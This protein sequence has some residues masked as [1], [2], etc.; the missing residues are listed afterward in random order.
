M[1]DPYSGK[2]LGS[3]A[4]KNAV[5]E[6]M[7]MLFSLHRWLLLDRIEEPIFRRITKPEA[8]QLYQRNRNHIIYPGSR[9]WC[10]HLVPAKNQK[11]ETGSE[12]KM[13]CELETSKS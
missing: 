10:H 9:Y 1:V 11:L 3:S 8:G 12:N 5:S 2:I 6:F 4:D 13:E 7:Q